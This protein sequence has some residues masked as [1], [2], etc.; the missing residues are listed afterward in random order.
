MTTTSSTITS[1]TINSPTISG[2]TISSPTITWTTSDRT[3]VRT[4]SGDVRAVPNAL[5]SE[6][7]KLT[8]LRA[9]K[10]ILAMTEERRINGN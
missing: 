2:P 1:P 7:I 5:R 6:W 4:R 9:N 8:A 3:A 10:W